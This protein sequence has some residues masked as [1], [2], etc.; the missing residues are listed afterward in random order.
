MHG[1]S[2]LPEI[3]QL[4]CGSPGFV[5][6]SESGFQGVFEIVVALEDGV[7]PFVS[8]GLSFVVEVVPEGGFPPL[9]GLSREEVA[10]AE[11]LR[12]S[13]SDRSVDAEVG[14]GLG[15]EGANASFLTVKRFGLWEL[16]GSRAGLLAYL[17]SQ[18]LDLGLH[19][20]K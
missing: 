3:L 14:F 20:G 4:S 15:Q 10:D 12:N 16:G 1:R 8:V 2:G 6:V 11:D 5:W 9:E 13:S 7:G 19:S 18:L 17:L